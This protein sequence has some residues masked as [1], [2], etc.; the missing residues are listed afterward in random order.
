VDNSSSFV[1]LIDR[2]S[3]NAINV[4][5]GESAKPFLAPSV[6]LRSSVE[7]C[8]MPSGDANVNRGHSFAEHGLRVIHRTANGICKFG[9]VHDHPLPHAFRRC[10]AERNNLHG[11]G[12][13]DLLD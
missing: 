9:R 7:A 12:L 6:E 3:Q 11:P 5:L 2:R 13:R 8:E 4:F 10:V 1:G